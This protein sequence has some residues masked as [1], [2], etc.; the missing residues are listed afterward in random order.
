MVTVDSTNLVMIPVEIREPDPSLQSYQ[1][2][3][4]SWYQLLHPEHLSVVDIR[5]VPS[6]NSTLDQ[7][8]SNRS[9]GASGRR[10]SM[11]WT[12]GD[13][14]KPRLGAHRP[15]QDVLRSPVSNQEKTIQLIR[16]PRREYN[17][18]QEFSRCTVD[19]W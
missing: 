12:K 18:E 8:L 17:H 9:P 14:Q 10:Q 15:P 7:D 4:I 5:V 11:V 1:Y 19:A 2:L 16:P 3:H 6:F 13:F